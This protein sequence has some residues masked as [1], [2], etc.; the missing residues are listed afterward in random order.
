MKAGDVFHLPD[1]AG[2]HYN[3]VLEVCA[4]G[5]VITCNFT[6]C[7]Y[8]SDWTCVV[9]VGEHDCITKKSVVNYRQ[10]DYCEAGE[11]VEALERLIESRKQ[12]LSAEL[13]AKIRQGALNSPR[14]SD[15]I[16]NALKAGQ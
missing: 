8:H 12:P 13:L 9:E 2:G 3:F 15:K 10:A 6:D 7:L 11:S 1:F 5:S 4:D 16:K 14:T